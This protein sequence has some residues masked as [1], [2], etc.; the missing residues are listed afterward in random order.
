MEG[1][2]EWRE[3]G[4]FIGREEGTDGRTENGRRERHRQ[5][6]LLWRRARRLILVPS[7][8]IKLIARMCVY[9]EAMS[10]STLA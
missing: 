9:V 4:T 5:T 2:R 1:A 3:G 8:F 10:R 7:D 6:K